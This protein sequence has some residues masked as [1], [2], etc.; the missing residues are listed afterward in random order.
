M[1]K[2]IETTDSPNGENEEDVEELTENEQLTALKEEKIK[3]ESTNKQ[4]F[5]RAKKA[6]AKAKELEE[7]EPKLVTKEG[8]LD[9]GAKALLRTHG[10]KEDDFEFVEKELKNSN[11]P[12]DDLVTNPYFISKL[13]EK[14]NYESVVDATP[15][16]S[17]R[18]GAPSRNQSEY[19]IRKGELPPNTPSNR[20]LRRE[21][22]NARLETEKNAS[23]FAD[24]PVVM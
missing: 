16:Q 2:E 21:V 19:W 9:L 12:L 20:Q 17:K 11:M 7:A 24:N 3:L 4:L 15:E 23:K 22:V 18:A 6:E 8:K 1:E 14:R 13:N 5:E 10:I